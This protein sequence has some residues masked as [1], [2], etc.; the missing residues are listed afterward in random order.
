MK[1]AHPYLK[2]FS[3][4]WACRE[5]VIGFLQNRRKAE[6]ARVKAL[7]VGPGKKKLVP[8]KRTGFKPRSK[9]VDPESGAGPS[10]S[11]STS[12]EPTVEEQ[13]SS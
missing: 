6:N 10:G 11:A 4:D 5:L 7:V 9:T 12:T 3:H 1:R 2:A 8:S 13:L